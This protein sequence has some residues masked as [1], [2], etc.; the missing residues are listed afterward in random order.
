MTVN[1]MIAQLQEAAD[2]GFGNTEVLGAHQPNYPLQE[3]ILGV[4]YPDPVTWFK[5]AQYDLSDEDVEDLEERKCE[6][7]GDQA[8]QIWFV[9][10]GWDLKDEVTYRCDDDNPNMDEEGPEAT[11]SFVHVVLNGSGNLKTPYASRKLWD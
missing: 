5:V 11:G 10:D 7:C 8:T 6:C 4:R 3:R 2:A 1:E 9:P